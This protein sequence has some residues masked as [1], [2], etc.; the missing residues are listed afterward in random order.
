[1]TPGPHTRLAAVIGSPV[2]HSLSPSIH[3]AAF[4]ATG[5]DWVYVAFE[6][7]PGNGRQAIEAARHLGLAGLS[8]TM[9]HKEAAAESVDR[10]SDEAAALRSVNCVVAEGDHLVGHSTDGAGFIDSLGDARVD[11]A[12]KR[13]MVL[14]AGGAARAVVRALAASSVAEVV[15]V[16]RREAQG[17]VVV[18]LAGTVGRL[19][20]VADAEQVDIIINATPVGM[21]GGTDPSGIPVPSEVLHDGHVVVDLVYEPHVTPLLRVASARGAVT[22]GGLGMLVHQAAHAFRLWTGHEPPLAEMR[23]AVGLGEAD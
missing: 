23:A 14:G 6:V 1:M 10:L 4:A 8:V 2:R 20:T 19:G 15:V 16:T 5:L 9:P 12:G 11:P 22:V 18:A 3:N 7:A 21:G 17:R 13:A